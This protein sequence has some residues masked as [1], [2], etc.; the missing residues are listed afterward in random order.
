MRHRMLGKTDMEISEIGLGGWSIGGDSYGPTDDRES[1]AAIRRA[2]DLGITFY[3]TA[4]M[5]GRGRSERLIAEALRGHTHEV[6]IA[7]KVGYDFYHGPMEK[8]FS[9][10]YL[11]FAAEQS[12]KRLETDR[13]D[14]LQLHTPPLE[15]LQ[16]GEI[17]EV[18]DR[19]QDEGKIRYYG[20]SLSHSTPPEAAKIV[21]EKSRAVSLQIAYNFLRQDQLAAIA[22]QVKTSGIGIIVRTPLEYG[23]LTG[24][25]RENAIFHPEDHRANRWTPEEL[26]SLIRKVDA[27]RFL[28]KGTDLFSSPENKSVPFIRSLTEA[29]LRFILANLLVSV[30][31]PGVKTAAQVEEHVRASTERPYLTDED[32]RK[33]EAEIRKV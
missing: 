5:Y 11:R 26:S 30:V 3:D 29:A 12:L 15:V 22:D 17:F 28:I 24:K 20:V 7:T 8:N 14:L 25:Y 13:I 21:I 4:D 31:I 16:R 32:L 23:L 10:E 27:L 6:V 33:I 9:G 18:L 2:F 1:I 19:L